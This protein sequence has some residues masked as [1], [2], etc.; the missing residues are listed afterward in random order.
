MI[1]IRLPWLPRRTAGADAETRPAAARVRPRRVAPAPPAPVHSPPSEDAS[2]VPA[3]IRVA[4]EWAWRGI[5]IA[6]ALL[7][8]LWLLALLSEIVIPVI[9][10]LLLSALLSP[11]YRRLK[12]FLPP[13][14]AAALTVIGTLAFIAGA[15][16]FVA[17]QFVDQFDGIR[18]QVGAGYDQVR[19]WV[20]D[21]FGV[22][23]ARIDGWIEAARNQATEYLKNFGPQA[24][25]A[26]LTVGHM[27]A[28]FF[29]TMFTLFFFLHDGG[30]IWNWCVRLFPRT[31]RAKVHSSGRI[32]WVQLSAF[33]RA[34]IIVA[35][36]DAIGIGAVAAIL[37]VPFAGG[38]AIL[39]FF[40]AFIPIVGAAVSG[41]VAV[42]LALVALGPV[43]ALIMLLGVVA[44]MQIESHLLQPLLLG[45][46]M[47][48][49]PLSVILAIAAGIVLA[50][51]VGALIAVPVVAVLNAVGHH[52][53]D[54]PEEDD[55]A[56][57]HDIGADEA[58]VKAERVHGSEHRRVEPTDHGVP[59]E[60]AAVGDAIDTPVVDE[61]DD[62][63][64][65]RH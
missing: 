55:T 51:V 61:Q 47:K 40:G 31:V 36:V 27:V 17:T 22:T 23:A 56:F 64:P 8:I 13:G 44:V 39:V 10:A 49:H 7:A 18:T 16:A 15:L 2:A 6:T 30:R 37:G 26:G 33:T 54:G 12:S 20:M 42:L 19:V 32:A 4:S 41:T 57:V 58:D 25:S 48:V 50:G 34:T 11:V 52:L 45:R 63:G 28:G 35:A 29:V 38:V 46:V 59:G 3:G 14:L 1:D 60:S 53:L 9:V 24:A 65:L 62:P 21:T 5:V 43:K